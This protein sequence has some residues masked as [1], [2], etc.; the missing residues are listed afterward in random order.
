MMTIRNCGTCRFA[1]YSIGGMFISLPEGKRFCCRFCP[2]R[3][4]WPIVDVSDVCGE[5]E[6]KDGKEGDKKG[7]EK[8]NEA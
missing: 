4:R 3:G 2:Q 5:W 6:V 7:Q 1:R 8:N